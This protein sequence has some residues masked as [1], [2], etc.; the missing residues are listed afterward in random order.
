MHTARAS[1]H[2]YTVQ[3]GYSANKGQYC[4]N[5]TAFA[6]QCFA[7]VVQAGC[8]AVHIPVTVQI[9][10]APF[11]MLHE[12]E[13]VQ[14]ISDLVLV[15]MIPDASQFLTISDLSQKYLLLSM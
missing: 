7:R 4:G 9:I 1:V 6:E 11:L 13:P 3:T 8:S 14:M 15:L 5:S 2:W 12:C 10:P